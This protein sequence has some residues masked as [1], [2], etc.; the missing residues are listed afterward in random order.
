MEPEPAKFNVYN[1]LA[2]LGID[3]SQYNSAEQ[4]EELKQLQ[5]D[6]NQDQN[7]K[8]VKNSRMVTHI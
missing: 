5:Q 8:E 2:N 3:L 6:Q 1:D 4:L 7:Q